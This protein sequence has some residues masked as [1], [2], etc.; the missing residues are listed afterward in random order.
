MPLSVC[1][2]FICVQTLF[3]QPYTVKNGNTRHRFAQLELGI[4]QIYTPNAGTTQLLANNGKV[5]DYRFGTLNTTAL[6]IGATHFWGH[7]DWGL[8]IPIF[9]SGSGMRYGVDL[10]TKIYPWRIQNNRLRPFAGISMSPFGYSQ[11]D[12]GQYAQIK[13]PLVGGLNYYKNGHQFELG[14]IYSYDRKFDYYISRT[15]IGQTAIPQLMFNATYKYTLETTGGRERNWRNGTTKR[16]TDSLG[17]KGKLNGF[18]VAIGPSSAFRVANSPYNDQTRPYLGKH[19]FSMFADMGLGYYFYK[20][21][22]HINLAYRRNGSTIDAYGVEQAAKRRS[23]TLEVFKFLGDYHGF[24]PFIGPT[25]NYENLSVAE[26]DGTNPVINAGFKGIKPGLIFGWDIR[27]DDLQ[28]WTLRTNLRWT[29]NLGVAMPNGKKV[30]LDQL[31]FN[32]IQ[33]VIYPEKMF[34]NKLKRAE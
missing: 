18:S 21:D 4:T 9:A 31:E 1:F 2:I 14:V 17:A 10:Q 30:M 7:L 27:P 29:P 24:V 34:G 8:N 6:F 26:T 12:G 25:I 23:V 11:L 19:S 28:P 33:L 16:V 32:F 5:I 22:L 3:A 13:W 15:A 20:P